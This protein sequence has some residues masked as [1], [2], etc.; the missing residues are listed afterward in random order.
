MNDTTHLIYRKRERKRERKLLEF[1]INV[2][3]RISRRISCIAY[4]DMAYQQ[5]AA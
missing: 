2:V 5:R 4:L 3:R 1:S